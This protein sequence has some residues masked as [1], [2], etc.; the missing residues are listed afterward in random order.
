MLPYLTILTLIPLVGGVVLV[1]LDA[2][3]STLPRW[4]ALLFHALSLVVAL[5]ILGLFDTHVG[6]MQLVEQGS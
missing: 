3:P 2:K 1:G 4:L 5:V 6:G